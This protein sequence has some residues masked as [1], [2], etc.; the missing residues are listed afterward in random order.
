MIPPKSSV[1]AIRDPDSIETRKSLARSSSLLALLAFAVSG[2]AVEPP[3]KA[4]AET[5]PEIAI[6]EA[7]ST[8]DRGDAPVATLD[9]Q[10]ENAD[11]FLTLY[12]GVYSPHE[13]DLVEAYFAENAAIEAR[14]PVDID[15]LISGTL[16]VDTPGIGPM[17]KVSREWVEYTNAKY[18][19]ENPLRMDADYAKAAGFA[20]ILALP[21]F[22]AHDDSYMVPFPPMARDTLLVSDLN[23]AVT[24]YEPIYP[25][26]SL[27][28]VMDKRDVIDLTPPEGSKYR[29]VA[30]ESKG[31]IYNQ[32]GRKVNDVTFRVTESVKVYK[33]EKRPDGPPDF[34]RIWE[35]PNWMS[36]EEH[37]YSDADWDKIK[38]IWRAETRQGSA[39]LYW[40]D[41]KVGDAPAWTLD[42][43]IESS[44]APVPPWGLGKGGSRTLKAEIL[45]DETFSTMIKN[46][47]DGIYRTTD[48]ETMVPTPP[49]RPTEM[50]PLT[51]PFAGGGPDEGAINTTDIHKDAITRSPLINYIG[52]EYATRHIGNWMGD[53][54]WLKTMRWS[55]MDPRSHA[56]LGKPVP[57]NPRAERF[58]NRV[59][60]LEGR[61]VT[62]HG[63]TKDVAIVKSEVVSKYVEDGEFLVDLVWWIE[64]I[65]G[66]IWEE[67]MATVRLPS[68]S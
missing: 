68:K 3:Q 37:V 58:L 65:N 15:A 14:G 8:V 24:T 66:E 29:T 60:S 42:G 53:Q 45:D 32:H 9:D 43:P 61:Y 56:G 57:T 62:T 52:R 22:A 48:R 41:V 21:M 20:D 4:A 67:G 11:D 19:W 44:V 10:L 1:F 30:I 18:D 31:S 64:T 50:A 39:P 46:D 17:V 25:G 35:A 5:T 6:V 2:C 28:M 13:R 47:N 23:H 40:Q 26:D 54:G 27:F 16:P 55:I 49:E 59:A 34:M 38:D 36:R 12:P 33:D 63:L 7:V 51:G